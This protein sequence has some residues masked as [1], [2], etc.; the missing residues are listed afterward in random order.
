MIKKLL[1]LSMTTFISSSM[2]VNTII[3]PRTLDEKYEQSLIIF[4]KHLDESQLDSTAK[5]NLIKKL[6]MYFT[7][8]LLNGASLTIN[9]KRAENIYTTIIQLYHE[10]LSFKNKNSQNSKL[11]AKQFAE[12]VLG[13]IMLY[14][15]IDI[16]KTTKIIK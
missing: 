11:K 10:I 16:I 5:E 13:K 15:P 2:G 8:N 1:L 6:A 12:Q 3:Q 14:F 4:Q 7:P 9:N